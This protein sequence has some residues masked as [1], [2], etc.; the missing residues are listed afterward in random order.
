M[1]LNFKSLKVCAV[2]ISGFLNINAFANSS[3]AKSP[4]GILEAQNADHMRGTITFA[5]YLADEDFYLVFISNSF[6]TPP[7]CDAHEPVLKTKEKS[8]FFFGGSSRWSGSVRVCILRD[9]VVI[10]DSLSLYLQGF[11]D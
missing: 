11:G 2:C 7:P 9:G 3:V 5:P 4:F 6:T 1:N 8:V 10:D